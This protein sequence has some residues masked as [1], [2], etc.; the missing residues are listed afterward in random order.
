EF[1]FLHARDPLQPD[2]FDEARIAAARKRIAAPS[3]RAMK[4][5]APLG[6][7]R[8]CV[9]TGADEAVEPGGIEPHALHEAQVSAR[10]LAGI[11]QHH[12]APAR[13][14]QA[15]HAFPRAGIGRN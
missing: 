13:L 12:D 14:A 3:E 10:R 4:W 7:R 1:R 9:F 15:L 2:A 8:A 11:R 5:L 6:E